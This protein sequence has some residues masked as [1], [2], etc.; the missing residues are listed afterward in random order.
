MSGA[1][2]ST[3][4]PASPSALGEEVTGLSSLPRPAGWR[5][6]WIELERDDDAPP[7]GTPRRTAA[8]TG[9]RGTTPGLAARMARIAAWIA[10]TQPA[11]LVVDVSVEVAVLGA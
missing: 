7:G 11:V 4:R 3:T 8:C 2:T 1:V 5:G 9:H 10:A 6:P